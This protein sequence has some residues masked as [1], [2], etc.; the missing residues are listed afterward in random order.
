MNSNS[1]PCLHYLAKITLVVVTL[2]S[3][4]YLVLYFFKSF[5]VCIC[6]YLQPHSDLSSFSQCMFLF[7]HSGG[8]LVMKECLCRRLKLYEWFEKLEKGWWVSRFFS[9]GN[10]KTKLVP[11][12]FSIANGWTWKLLDL[13]NNEFD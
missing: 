11:Y 7:N 6:T 3:D 9:L 4:N 8:V 12:Y 10:H 2:V 1:L 5:H 13:V